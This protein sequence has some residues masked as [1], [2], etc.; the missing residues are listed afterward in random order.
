MFA[1]TLGACRPTLDAPF[2]ETDGAIDAEDRRLDHGYALLLDLLTEESK[3]AGVLAIK[4]PSEATATLLR[5]ISTS[6]T[7]GAEELRLLLAGPP[8]IAIDATGLP[9]IET[10][11]RNRIA[12]RE[13]VALLISGGTSFERRILLTQDK[14]CGYLAALAA[15]LA[16]A[17]PAPE[18]RERLEALSAAFDRLAA[19]IR[20][21]LA[22]RPVEPTTG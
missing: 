2:A 21:R 17:D 1:S 6:A 16:T 3:V 11:A 9:I 18:R 5:D 4:S 8:A 19:R 10:D 13:T 14:A 20:A 12:N 7:A 15:S 22:V